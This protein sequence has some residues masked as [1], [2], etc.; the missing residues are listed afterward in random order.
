M[1]EV[2]Q[3]NLIAV[4]SWPYPQAQLLWELKALMPLVPLHKLQNMKLLIRLPF[5][6]A[7]HVAFTWGITLRC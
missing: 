2:S 3:L 6:S 4:P 5:I 1:P 7:P